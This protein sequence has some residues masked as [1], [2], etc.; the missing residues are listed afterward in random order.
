MLFVRCPF[1][2]LY[3]NK[4]LVSNVMHFGKSKIIQSHL[5]KGNISYLYFNYSTA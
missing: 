4:K 1:L 2:G 5:Y 3:I